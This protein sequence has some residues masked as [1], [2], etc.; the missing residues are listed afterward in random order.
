MA[1]G[2][3]TKAKATKTKAKAKAIAP[4]AKAKAKAKPAKA[5]KIEVIEEREPSDTELML[6]TLACPTST[7]DRL[8]EVC[9]GAIHAVKEDLTG[10]GAAELVWRNRPDREPLG[11]AVQSLATELARHAEVML[12][13]YDRLRSIADDET[14]HADLELEDVMG[15]LK[16]MLAEMPGE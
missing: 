4:K 9:E 12:A 11:T 6:Q 2:K 14:D 7:A 16:P 5:Q 3:Q 13:I 1:R 8:C 15:R 10:I